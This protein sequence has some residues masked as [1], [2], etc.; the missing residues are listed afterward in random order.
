MICIECGEIL[1]EIAKYCSNCG[2]KQPEMKTQEPEFDDKISEIMEN[3]ETLD[4]NEKYCNLFEAYKERKLPFDQGYIISSFFSEASLYSIYEV[5]YYASLKEIFVTSEGLHFITSGKKLYILVEP[6]TYQLKNQ[7]PVSRSKSS[8][9]YIPFRFNEMDIITTKNQTKIM[10][11]KEPIN[12]FGCYTVFEPKGSNF[13]LLF[14]QLPDMFASI[15]TLFKESLNK[16]GKIYENDAMETGWCI[17]TT[18]K[19]TMGWIYR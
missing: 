4:L 14:Y 1:E 5:F 2:V 13:A 10:I 19:K 8:G 7:E 12:L 16:H 6:P 18:I 17:A 11:A 15:A 9:E 3:E